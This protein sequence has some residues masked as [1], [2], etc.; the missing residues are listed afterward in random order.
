MKCNILADSGVKKFKRLL[1][2]FQTEGGHFYEQK[3]SGS[4]AFSCHEEHI[5]DTT[6]ALK[7]KFED[8][9]A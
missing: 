4:K 2:C 5:H 7:L 1:E 9:E 8:L 6:N 3:E